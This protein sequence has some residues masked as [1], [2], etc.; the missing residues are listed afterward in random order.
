MSIALPKMVMSN[1]PAD[2]TPI[3]FAYAVH[4]AVG[5]KMVGAESMEI[6]A[7]SIT[8]SRMVTVSRS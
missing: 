7:R 2:S 5:N 6:E 3:D 1:L 8:R 4:S